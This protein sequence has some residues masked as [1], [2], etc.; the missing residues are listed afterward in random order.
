MA[1]YMMKRCQAYIEL[2][3]TYYETRKK[4]S[5]IKQAIRK[6]ELLGLEVTVTPVA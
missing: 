4:D 5:V 3:P 1:Y 6:L 2:G